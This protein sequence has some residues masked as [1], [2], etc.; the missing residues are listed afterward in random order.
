MRGTLRRVG[1]RLRKY[2]P[3]LSSAA[4]FLW[5]RLMFRTTFLAITGSAGKS[6]A[7]ACLGSILSAHFPTNWLPGG[8]NSRP[9]LARIILKTRFRH[10]FTAIEVGTR[11]PGALRRAAWM[12]APDIA[13]V[14]RVLKVHSNV[15]A[16]EADV[17]A[18]KVQLLSRMSK[19]GIAILNADDPLVMGM[20]IGC[21]AQ[22][23]TFGVSP[24]AFLIADQ[25]SAAWPRRLTFRARCGSQTTRVETSLVGE[26]FL[27]SVLAAL[28]AAVCCGVP[29]EEAALAVRD[30]QPVPGR[31]APMFLPNGACV[32]RDEFNTTL[33]GLE[34]SLDF[35]AHAQVARR[36][37]LIGDVLDTGLTVR[38]RFDDIGRRVGK[39][40]DMAVFLGRYGRYAARAAVTAG[41]PEASVRSFEDL[42]EASAFL[43][44]ELRSGDLVLSGGW[45]GRH[46]ER[47]ALALLGD[48][49]CWMERCPKV[50][51]CDVCSELRLVPFPPSAGT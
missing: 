33:P 27:P 4:A 10:R 34:V 38:P 17:A 30:V 8:S 21:R 9:V 43:R 12:I 39:A 28:T 32:I 26:H 40:A 14:L 35:L 29:L 5:R 45:S 46:T 37:V 15:F 47:V 41:M 19:R 7:T 36:I 31:M 25:V 18:E 1:R 44:S 16:T 50:V 42:P 22:I 48:I 3:Y 20:A 23:R 49:A 13:V 11:A 51:A 6:T 24:G 2:T